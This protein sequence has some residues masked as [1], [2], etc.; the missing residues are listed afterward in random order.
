MFKCDFCGCSSEEGLKVHKI[1]TKFRLKRYP[2]RG[3]G[4]EI[5]SEKNA[6]LDCV[7]TGVAVPAE[8]PPK[9]PRRV[10]I[11]KKEAED[12][13]LKYRRKRG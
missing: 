5:V 4:W 13:H 8:V 2:H 9:S 7:N 6:C 12:N 1:I 3:K 11:K 10:K